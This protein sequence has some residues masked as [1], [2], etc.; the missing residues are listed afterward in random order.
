M[1][2]TAWSDSYP[3]YEERMAIISMVCRQWIFYDD[4]PL[5]LV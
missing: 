3:D 5:K 1:F 2:I 4:I